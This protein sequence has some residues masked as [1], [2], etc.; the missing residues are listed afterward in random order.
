MEGT[1]WVKGC[2]G[3]VTFKHEQGPEATNKLWNERLPSQRGNNPPHGTMHERSLCG[4]S[5]RLT[6]MITMEYS[7]L[8]FTEGH[9]QMKPRCL[10]APQDESLH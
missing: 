6:P 7:H 1:E 2:C 8:P 3:E 4:R 9:P 5:R 10:S